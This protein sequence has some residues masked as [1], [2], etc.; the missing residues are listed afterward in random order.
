M[1]TTSLLYRF[2]WIC[3]FAG[4]FAGAALLGAVP[5]DAQTPV[6]PA[7]DRVD[8]QIERGDDIVQ[9][10]AV[11]Y[12][13]VLDGQDP[14]LVRGDS[15]G[16]L[17][18]PRPE[19]L[20]AIPYVDRGLGVAVNLQHAMVV[21]DGQVVDVQVS[22]AATG[23]QSSSLAAEVRDELIVL[24]PPESD[25]FDVAIPDGLTCKRLEPG[26]RED[27]ATRGRL[28]GDVPCKQVR[29]IETV[30]DVAAWYE[31]S[32]THPQTGVRARPNGFH[33]ARELRG[34]LRSLA[35][36]GEQ[37]RFVLVATP[38]A[39]AVAAPRVAPILDTVLVAP[40]AQ[41]EGT[42]RIETVPTSGFEWITT[43]GAL[44]GP[45]R[46]GLPGRPNDP[47][48]EADRVK[49]D[50][51]T[52]LRWSVSPQQRY[53]VT[54]FGSTQASLSDNPVGNHHD[55]PYGLRLAARFGEPG[56]TGLELRLEGSYEDDPFQR[57]TLSTGDQRIRVLFGLDRGS[58]RTGP[59]HW[60]LS[61]GPTYFVDRSN[62]W[63]T[64]EDARQLGY[65]L[66]GVYHRNVEF[67]RLPALLSAGVRM[68]QSWGYVQDA[69]NRNFSVTGRLS[70]KPRVDF[71]GT[72]IAIGP[73]LY[74]HHMD[75]E[76]ADTPGF[77]ESNAQ[78]GVELTSWITF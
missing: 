38:P 50:A 63:E 4:L 53:E 18:V 72:M 58:V 41:V 21:E 67:L 25:A 2:F 32:M 9:P 31:A 59:T 17:Q 34:W 44:R 70:A 49:G 10:P 29:G 30:V 1:S 39:K 23:R 48:Y 26:S 51:M 76:Y 7:V 52:T 46:S 14:A 11:F 33:N 55:V 12:K 64:R 54:L 60:R 35:P 27:R 40:V 19:A 65:S 73:V 78:L 62:I 57:N 15:L 6:A 36:G 69:G 43:L 22:P 16:L 42:F 24:R 8:I 5:S 77:D 61:L 47:R 20:D 3:R 75:S 13:R 71:G 56:R 45:N 66:D 37:V 28:Y 68:D 74:L